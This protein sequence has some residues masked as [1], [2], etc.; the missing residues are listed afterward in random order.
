MDP[1]ICWTAR[2][3]YPG[4]NEFLFYSPSFVAASW[5]DLDAA[6]QAAVSE[7]WSK[8]SPHPA[9]AV[10]ELIPGALSFQPNSR[11]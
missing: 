1:R 10:V 7:A 5:A 4:R 3:A 8:I 11:Q 2:C 9:P 6:A